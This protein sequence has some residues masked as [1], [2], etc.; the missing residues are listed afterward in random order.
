MEKRVAFLNTPAIKLQCG[1]RCMSEKIRA[2]PAEKKC[3]FH[4]E[5][6]SKLG[7]RT[8]EISTPITAVIREEFPGSA[9][10]G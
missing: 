10:I 9:L 6:S 8:Q 2:R 4:K 3:K 7:K 5:G 1:P